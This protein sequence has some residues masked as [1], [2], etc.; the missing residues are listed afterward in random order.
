MTSSDYSSTSNLA[1]E[2]DV[3]IVGG[4]TAGLV[5]ATRLSEEPQ[6]NVLVLEAGENHANNPSVLTPGLSSTLM[7]NPQHDWGFESV[8][9]VS[10]ISLVP[11]YQF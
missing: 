6:L 3:I 10:S 9:Q 4:G 7:D 2:Y 5:L 1:S 8:S 11:S